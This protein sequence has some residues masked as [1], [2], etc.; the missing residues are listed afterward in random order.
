MFFGS[1]QNS[2]Q[3]ADCLYEVRSQLRWPRWDSANK[4][5]IIVELADDARTWSPGMIHC[6]GFDNSASKCPAHLVC[7]LHGGRK[8]CLALVNL[9]D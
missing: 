1:C 2:L 6:L 4:S 7:S 9:N 5:L 8:L 3:I